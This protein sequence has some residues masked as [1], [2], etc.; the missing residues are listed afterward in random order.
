MT[1]YILHKNGRYNIYS[2]VVDDCFFEPSLTLEE[3]K[4]YIQVEEGNRGL[5]ELDEQLERAHKT[6]S[7]SLI[8]NSLEGV[9]SCNHSGPDGDNLS[10]DEFVEIYLS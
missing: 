2:T 6:G 3:L 8:M 9:A 10:F 4:E 5:R 7:S 1:H